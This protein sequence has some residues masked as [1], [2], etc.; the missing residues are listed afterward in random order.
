[1]I[2]MPAT[3]PDEL[4]Q[5]MRDHYHYYRHLDVCKGKGAP[6]SAV[7]IFRMI[8]GDLFRARGMRILDLG[9]GGGDGHLPTLA[10]VLH[11]VGAEVI[12][13]DISDLSG[14][15]F[16][17]YRIDLSLPQS[18]DLFASEQFHIVHH[19]SLLDSPTLACLANEGTQR[20]MAAYLRRSAE[21]VLKTNGVYLCEGNPLSN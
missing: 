15:R 9:C 2:D 8:I 21:R 13:I 17:N 18:L 5:R 20:K 1:M 16:H 3:C 6:D 14:E 7:S 11:E 10:R 4:A 12:G 19:T